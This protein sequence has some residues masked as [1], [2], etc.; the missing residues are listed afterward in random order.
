MSTLSDFANKAISEVTSY[1]T[2]PS[3][4]GRAI[5]TVVA[6][7][8]GGFVGA[9]IG[10]NIGRGVTGPDDYSQA[11]TSVQSGPATSPSAG[12]SGSGINTLP[13][14]APLYNQSTGDPLLDSL[15]ARYNANL[16]PSS[17]G[18]K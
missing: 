2:N 1:A 18:I 8:I 10:S 5:G 9:Q 7:P 3:N 11:T 6:G 14:Y 13:L 16:S 12:G 4:I 17:F 15:I